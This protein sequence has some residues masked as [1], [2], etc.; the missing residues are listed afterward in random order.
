MPLAHRLRLARFQQPL[1]G[2]LAHRLQQPVARLPRLAPRTAT[3][4]F[5]TSAGRAGPAPPTASIPS[6]GARPPPP[7]PASSRRRRPTAAAAASAPA[8]RAGRSS[9]RSAPAASAGA[10]APSGCRRS[11]AGS[12]RPAARAICSTG[13]AF[14]RAAAS[15]IAS[16]MPSSRWQTCATAGAF[17]A[18]TAKAG[19]LSAARSTNSRTASYCVQALQRRAGCSGSGSE[20]D[21][22]R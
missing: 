20:S 3:S 18:V 10:A 21:G 16:G 7:P 13:S 6:P 2:I 14:T 12:G 15:S 19:W 9:S 11:A 4:D 22:T 5:S 1:P 17:A 8:R